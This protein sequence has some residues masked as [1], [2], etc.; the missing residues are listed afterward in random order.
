MLVN[1]AMAVVLQ[2][3]F[4]QPGDRLGRRYPGAQARG[5]H[6]RRRLDDDRGCCVRFAGDRGCAARRG[7]RADVARRD[8][9]GGPVPGNCR[10]RYADAER[11]VQYLAVFSLGVT[12]Q[13][14]RRAGPSSRL[15][16]SAHGAVGWLGPRRP[17]SLLAALLVKPAASALDRAHGLAAG[18][19]R[20]NPKEEEPCVT[21][22]A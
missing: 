5:R 12:A 20:A 1:T 21:L 2:V 19:D 14:N 7:D 10:Y 3:P 16:S 8:L 15:S 22:T 11:E 4:Q 9:A 17:P 18:R 6:A 13:D